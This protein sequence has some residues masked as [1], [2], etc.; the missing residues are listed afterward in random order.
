MSAVMPPC[1]VCGS[2]DVIAVA[3]GTASDASPYH[4]A[5][6]NVRPLFSEPETPTRA[7]CME[8]WSDKAGWVEHTFPAPDD[9]VAGQGDLFIADENDR[10]ISAAKDALR[11][12]IAAAKMESAYAEPFKG[13]VL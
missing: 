4:P 9:E 10:R 11:R 12:E 13:D 3:P 7:Y 5:C 8:C 1:C 6:I 2:A